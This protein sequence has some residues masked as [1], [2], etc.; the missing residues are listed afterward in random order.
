MESTVYKFNV[1]S[2]HFPAALEIFSQ[3]FKEPLFH[4]NSTA[5]EV[6]A[7]DAEDSKNRI[8]DGRRSLQVLKSLIIPSHRYAKFSTGNAMTLTSGDPERFALETR[9]AM[10]EF[11]HKHYGIFSSSSFWRPCVKKSYFSIFSA[12]SHGA[13]SCWSSVFRRAAS[14]GF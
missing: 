10:Q 13:G 8:L 4:E 2:S 3:F 6:R 9:K 12:F 14:A 7:V 5:R 11:Y 1:I